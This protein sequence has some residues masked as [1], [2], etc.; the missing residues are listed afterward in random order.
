MSLKRCECMCISCVL[1]LTLVDKYRSFLYY[2]RIFLILGYNIIFFLYYAIITEILGSPGGPVVKNPLCNAWD[3]NSSPGPGRCRR[4]LS[5][6]TTIIQPL[7]WSPQ[8]T[9]TETRMPWSPCSTREATA[10]EG[11]FAKARD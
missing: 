5:P 2:I 9:T 10:M 7:L 8:V 1:K 3:T 6:C 11:P 4:Q